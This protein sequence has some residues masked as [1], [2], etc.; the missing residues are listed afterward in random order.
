VSTGNLVV[1]ATDLARSAPSIGVV[2][3]RIYN[4]MSQSDLG[5]GY[6][7]SLN[8]NYVLVEDELGDITLQE[9]DGS[10]HVFNL[11][12]DGAYA[13]PAGV[14]MDLS[15]HPDGTYS[16]ARKDGLT[17]EF[18][19]TGK[20]TSI[21][22]RN[23]N[24]LT[25][26]Y[27]LVPGAGERLTG[28]TDPVG[29]L[30]TLTYDPAGRLTQV[31]DWEGR[32]YQ[33]AYDARGNLA[34]V[35]DPAGKRTAYRYDAYHQLT[36][37]AD[38]VGRETLVSLVDGKCLSITN[39]LGQV[40]SF[41][42]DPVGRGTTVTDSRG[43][44]TLL[45]YDQAGS[46]AK[47][48]D[49]L[50]REALFQCDADGNLT[51]L[52][53]IW[54]NTWLY[55]YDAMGNMIEAHDPSGTTT[56]TTFNQFNLP[57]GV[58]VYSAPDRLALLA[59]ALFTYDGCGNVLSAAESIDATQSTFRTATFHYDPER[60][61]FID[62]ATDPRGNVAEFTYD[63]YG[64]PQT[65][66]LYVS[67]P[68]GGTASV[69]AETQYDSLGNL[70]SATDPNGN[71]TRYEYDL[72]GRPIKVFFPDGASESVAYD[73]QGHVAVRTDGNGRRT[74]YQYDSLGRA[75]KVVDPL[76]NETTLA[77]DDANDRASVTKPG[78]ISATY[79]YDQIGRL[80]RVID[81]L[82][83]ATVYTYD[84]TMNKVTVTDPLGRWET[85]VYD[86][87]NL[88]TAYANAAGLTAIAYD[89]LGRKTSVTDPNS[90]VMAY[91]YDD[92]G[93]LL[94]VTDP[95]GE[96]IAYEYDQSDNLTR[97]TTRVRDSGGQYVNRVTTYVYD[98]LNRRTAVVL[99]DLEGAGPAS[100]SFTYDPSGNQATRTDGKGQTTNYDY[101][102]R[103]RLTQVQYP[104]GAE[105]S[106]TYDA[107]GNALTMK[108]S[109]G[110]TVYQYNALGRLTS[111][112]DPFGRTVR[113]SYDDLARR[114]TLSTDWGIITYQSDILGR[115]ETVTDPSGGVT[116]YHYD[117]AGSCNQVDYPNGDVITCAY[118]GVGRLTEIKGVHGAT[119]ISD[120]DYTYDAA[121]NRLT[122]TTS[123]GVTSYQYDGDYRLKKATRPGGAYTEYWYDEAGNRAKLTDTTG[124]V[125]K[126]TTYAYD[127]ND[128]LTLVTHPDATTTSYEYDGS[129]NQLRLV[130]PSGTTVFT[131]DE[132]NRLVGIGCPDGST[133]EYQYDGQGRRVRMKDPN[134][135]V[136]YQ[137]SGGQV[138]S[139]R[140]GAGAVIAYYIR[141]LGGRLVSNVQTAGTRYY[142][143]DGLG[144]VV[145]LTDAADVKV[146][147][148]TYDEFGVL[149][150]STGQ[151]WNSFKYTSS[152]YDS[153]P[154][155][156]LM[157]ARYYDP[158]L[159]RFITQDTWEGRTWEPWTK[160]L[161][162]YGRGNPVT[163]IDPTGHAALL[164]DGTIIGTEVDKELL[165]LKQ[166]YENA[167]SDEGRVRIAHEAVLL[168]QANPGGYTVLDDKSLDDYRVE[169][170]LTALE[171]GL[172]TPE[173]AF[174]PLLGLLGEPTA[175]VFSVGASGSIYAGIGFQIDRVTQRGGG[176]RYFHTSQAIVGSLG[177]S[178]N[179]DRGWAWNTESL[180]DFEGRS[181]GVNVTD[182][183]YNGGAAYLGTN[184][185]GEVM[186]LFYMGINYPKSEHTAGLV[187][188]TSVVPL[189]IEAP[190]QF[191]PD[192][193]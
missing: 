78:G 43:R 118:D 98:E 14:F 137:Y 7:W 80:K 184:S 92:L 127:L 139:D 20:I 66:T 58:S 26:S 187:W 104:S 156:Y 123:A 94:S 79:E 115:L 176:T 76:G 68:G 86:Y 121:G 164:P 39:A 107:V 167:T 132:E 112:T 8:C 61:G 11:N 41:V 128:R 189:S 60:P 27:T 75:L 140:D 64:Y 57:G 85:G 170:I 6:G 172:L 177:W 31:A 126:T 178:V 181:T 1:T 83:Q 109:L 91:S 193:N 63:V 72:L 179:I 151:S 174:E 158:A 52:T 18:D 37:V 49:A 45:E 90:K 111:E 162:A 149:T 161:Y 190:V 113:Y 125:A 119:V 59:E 77:Y 185:K 74:T 34:L 55:E 12:P 84:A 73:A 108:D 25:Y 114:G 159:G 155:L 22:D 93:R 192:Q 134:V 13:R 71:V 32:A 160:N 48:T 145:A 56:V 10:A 182:F 142:H 69:S 143:F 133:V 136:F 152:I 36:S 2:I 110:T 54:D 173:G 96:V 17:Y 183:Y 87:R 120:Y 81:G 30:V 157:G 19:A 116:R 67:Q 153:A 88:L 148:Y 169:G 21:S 150:Q 4:S 102:S 105:V 89:E 46:L 191:G 29:R 175:E 24:T 70:V 15:K 147:S 44:S 50:G 33:Y 51:Q 188:S 40:T 117:P 99:P 106:Y 122:T 16:I 95:M 42:Y 101:D 141:G 154:D 135:E 35:T 47:R 62:F 165:A 138:I 163:F 146:S 166:A 3:R 144:S 38:K 131:Y 5:F 103:N 130:Q 53:D 180:S 186:V 23:G 65:V 129:G 100:S 168:R 97:M 82:G 124:G 171:N 9:G 28:I